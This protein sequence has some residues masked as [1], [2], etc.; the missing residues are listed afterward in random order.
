M[1]STIPSYIPMSPT[2]SDPNLQGD[3]HHT[4]FVQP[5]SEPGPSTPTAAGSSAPLDTSTNGFH[6]VTEPDGQ[7]AAVE[8]ASSDGVGAVTAGASSDSPQVVANGHDAAL[9]PPAGDDYTGARRERAPGSMLQTP[10]LSRTLPNHAGQ[11]GRTVPRSPHRHYA[12]YLLMRAAREHKQASHRTQVLVTWVVVGLLALLTVAV[13]VSSASAAIA[14]YHSEEPALASMAHTVASR[15]SVRIFD[16]R[17]VLLYQFNGDGAQHS[18]PLADVPV[19][20]VNATIATEDH[21]FWINQGVDF[22]AIARAAYTDAMASHLQEGASTITQQLIKQNV[23]SSDPTFTRKVKEAILSLGLTTQGPFTKA[24]ILQ[25]YLNSIPYGPTTYG[26]DAAAT[27][28]FSYTD[29]PAT[30]ETAAQHLDLAQASLLAGIPESPAYNNPLAGPQGL[31][32]ARARQRIVLSA[33]VQQGYVTPAEANAAWQEAGQPKFFHPQFAVPDLAPHFVT[34]VRQQLD[35]MVSAGQLSAGQLHDVT[36]AGLN[37]YTTLDLDLQNHVQQAMLDHL[38]GNDVNDYPGSAYL[39]KRYIRQDNVTNAAAVLADHHTGAIR[40]LLGSMDYYGNTSCHTG[41]NGQFDVATQGYRPP[42][43]SFKPIVYATA[44]AQGWS[45]AT[46]VHNEPTTFWDPGSGPY[47]PHDADNN[48][49]APNMTVRNALQL[50]QNIPAVETMQFA[51]IQ[52]VEHNAQLWGIHDW[53]GVWG[54]SSAIGSLDVHPIDMVQA[55]SVFANYGL[56][57]PLHAMDHITDASGNMVYQ[58]QQPKPVR[59]LSPQVAFMISSVLS[60]NQARAPEFGRCS[61]LYLDPSSDDC[62]YFNGNSPHSWP[63]AAKTGTADDLTNDWAMGYTM[64]YTMGVW[65]GNNDDSSM[66]WVDGVTGAAPIW[67]HSM[68]YA[69]RNLPRRAF[70]VPSGMYRGTSASHGITTTDWL[71]GK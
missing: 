47:S 27:T 18:I 17:G 58:Y 61:V 29:N 50:S 57:I 5:F 25:M 10:R 7:S 60:D 22:Q 19:A 43:S 21:D 41:V 65:V 37:I 28:Y 3:G 69:E 26:I 2:P 20:L 49:L 31:A 46:I 68:L 64:D 16:S 35:Q 59:V 48:H 53:N 42:G 1:D 36:R 71:I 33:M 12:A 30:G 9:A 51:G 34:Y 6:G 32:H 39:G 44:F 56:Y 4:P 66:Q 52:N 8:Q 14:Y 40:V 70:P 55:Y 45:P 23:L 38:C 54:L 11:L 63:A 15:D 67:Y 62:Y 24:Q 13:L